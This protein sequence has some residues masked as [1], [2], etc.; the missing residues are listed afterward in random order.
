MLKY[1]SICLLYILWLIFMKEAIKAFNEL[2]SPEQREAC[3]SLWQAIEL[4][5]QDIKTAMEAQLEH[6][7]QR[8][9]RAGLTLVGPHRDR[10]EINLNDRSARHYGS[11]GQKRCAMLAMKLAVADRLS[12]IKQEQVTLILDEVF[13]E[14]D[15]AKSKALIDVLTGHRQVFI[16]TAGDFDFTGIPVKKYYIDNGKV[17]ETG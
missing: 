10:L 3:I 12:E 14:L 17:N 9:I 13:A 11:R 5:K 4:E 7:R 6:Y 1:L 16:A 15:K 2:I 8:E